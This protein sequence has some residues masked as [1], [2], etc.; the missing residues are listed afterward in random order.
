MNNKKI[1]ANM[2]INVG[3]VADTTEL[4]KQV[5]NKFKGL[6][7]GSSL[8][9][10][11]TTSLEK[12]FKDIYSNL[13]KMASSLSKRG[14]STKQYENLFNGFNDNI[15]R[16]IDNIE[17]LKEKITEMYNSSENKEYT[18][19]LQAQRDLLADMEKIATRV[20]S[21]RTRA[22]TNAQKAKDELG[23]DFAN[24]VT[25]ELLTSITERRANKKGL[26]PGQQKT[27]FGSF[28]PEELERAITL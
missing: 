9:S 7:L 1:Q 2:Q 26:T 22:G 23:L 6:N 11:V 8:F 5:E 3:F 28:S 24:S 18:K 14:L 12:N 10:G 21:A 16:S 19:Q 13:D 20:K 25:A 15:L 17:K 27:I 4:V